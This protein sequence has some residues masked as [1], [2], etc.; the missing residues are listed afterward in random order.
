MR[1]LASRWCIALMLGWLAVGLSTPVQAAGLDDFT[2]ARC[3]PGDAF[4]AVHARDHAGRDFI[5][6]QYERVWKVVEAQ[7]FERDLRTLFKGLLT[8]QPG[9][10]VDAFELQW[11]QFSDLLMAVEWSALFEREM[12]FAMKMNFPA[13][14]LVFLGQSST[15]KAASNFQGLEGIAKRLVEIAGPG[16][17]VLATQG[18]GD[19]VVHTISFAQPEIP[20][21]VMLARHQDILLIGLGQTMPEQ[22]LTLLREHSG[23]TLAGGERFQAAFKRLPPPADGLVF[24]DATRFAG[25][26]RA[27]ADTMFGMSESAGTTLDPKIKALPGRLIDALDILDY[28]ASVHTTEGQRATEEGIAVL[29]DDAKGRALYPVVFSNPPFDQPLKYVPQEA[30]GFSVWTGVSLRALYDQVLKFIREDV[31][32]GENL[33]A[34]WEQ[35]KLQMPF[36]LEEDVLGWVGG[37]VTTFS[38]P[39]RSAYQPGPWLLAISVSDEAKARDVLTRLYAQVEPLLAANGGGA[40]RDAEIPGTEGFKT[41]VHPI[42]VM[43]AGLGQP[44]IGVHAG[45]LFIA[46]SPKVIQTALATAA[47]E[48]PNFAKNERFLKEGLSVGENVIALSFTDLTRF[49]EELGQALSMVQLIGTFAPQIAQEPLVKALLGAAGKAGRVARELNFYQSTC[50][51]TTFDGKVLQTK[52]IT[53]YR[54]P[55]PPATTVPAESDESAAPATA[56]TT[57][58]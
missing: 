38:M 12:A 10:D 42:F 31:P 58:P 51:Q 49:G 37:A 40:L 44:T 53:N 13:P 41:V 24:F 45:Q 15:A 57:Q 7:H 52:S 30:L 39:A 9:A 17:L 27:Y 56:P 3:I 6:A 26:L 11:Q 14:E 32:D 5:D 46:A 21:A 47:G 55:P 54:E 28:A 43:A 48:Q 23:P 35:T 4:L 50:S 16:M 34:Q 22:T 8:Q 33:I 25:Q 18:E 29:R 36:S 20:F 1:L 19:S 2:L